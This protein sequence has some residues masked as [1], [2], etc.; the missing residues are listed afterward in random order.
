[1]LLVPVE[2]GALAEHVLEALHGLL[3]SADVLRSGA[4]ARLHCG[5]DGHAAV[6]LLNIRK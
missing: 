6:V 1:M 2:G 5:Q 3:H 4:V